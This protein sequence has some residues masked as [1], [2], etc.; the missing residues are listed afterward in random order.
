MLSRMHFKNETPIAVR[1]LPAWLKNEFSKVN[2]FQNVNRTTIGRWIRNGRQGVK[3]ETLKLEKGTHWT[4]EEAFWRFLEASSAVNK[5]KAAS[6]EQHLAA[7][8]HLTAE[9]CMPSELI[10]P[11]T[12]E[13]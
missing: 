12:K 6:R 13:P 7:I 3:L 4:T 9:G 2:Q 1:D 8:A 11:K 5:K 10:D